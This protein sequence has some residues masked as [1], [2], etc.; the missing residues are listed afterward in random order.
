MHIR[1]FVRPSC[2]CWSL[3]TGLAIR[4]RHVVVA[5]HNSCMLNRMSFHHSNVHSVEWNNQSSWS[6][7]TTARQQL[8]NAHTGLVFIAP[9]IFAR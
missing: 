3:K 1:P 2:N 5:D 8:I 4:V 7:I 9:A 6:L